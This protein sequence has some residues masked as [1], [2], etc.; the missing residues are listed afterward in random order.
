MSLQT[1]SFYTDFSSCYHELVN[2]YEV[3][4]DLNILFRIHLNISIESFKCSKILQEQRKFQGLE[5]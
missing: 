4:Q 3:V 2:F 1:L 5:R